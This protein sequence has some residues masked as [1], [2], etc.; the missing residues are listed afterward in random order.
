MDNW[1]MSELVH[2]IIILAHFHSFSSF[3][4]GCG[5][6][7]GNPD[8][9]QSNQGNHQHEIETNDE[10]DDVLEQAEEATEAMGASQE[11]SRGP[12]AEKEVPLILKKMETLRSNQEALE[13]A[14]LARR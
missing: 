4:L 3:A 8:S 1:S 11:S 9:D 7:S 2:A 13:M 6:M 5:K 12:S 10:E 14:E